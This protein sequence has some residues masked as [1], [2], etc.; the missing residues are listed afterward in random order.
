MKIY[1]L[2]EAQVERLIEIGMGVHNNIEYDFSRLTPHDVFNRIK[3]ELSTLPVEF[4]E[5]T[6]KDLDVRCR[7]FP[8]N[9]IAGFTLGKGALKG[10]FVK[11]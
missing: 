4:N 2:T 8:A 1:S 7:F 9:Q 3:E 6:I 10:V 11:E 5:A